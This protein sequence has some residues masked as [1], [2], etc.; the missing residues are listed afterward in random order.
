MNATQQVDAVALVYTRDAIVTHEQAQEAI[1]AATLHG[2]TDLKPVTLDYWTVIDGDHVLP[3]HCDV[4]MYGAD[5]QDE[6][7]IQAIGD[8]CKTPS[9]AADGYYEYEDGVIRFLFVN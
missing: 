1:Y 5:E 7:L 3:D 6:L 4:L 9:L 2:I 8:V